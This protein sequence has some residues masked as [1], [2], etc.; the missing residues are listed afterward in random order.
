[1]IDP[2][3]RTHRLRLVPNLETSRSLAFE[4]VIRELYP[5]SVQPGMTPSAAAASVST[6]GPLVNGKPPALL[7]KLGRYTERASQVPPGAQN[8][9]AQAAAS[10]GGTAAPGASSSVG[11][12]AVGGAAAGSSAAGSVAPVERP[13]TGISGPTM[14]IAGGGG[15]VTAARVAFKSKVVSRSHAEIW[16]D[17]SGKVSSI[18]RGQVQEPDAAD[19]QFYIRD[20]ASSSGTF[21][22]NIRLSSPNTASRHTQINDGDVLQLGVDYQGGQED[23]FR[24]IKMRVEVGREWQRGANEFKWVPLACARGAG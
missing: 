4:P 24:C 2:K 8:V 1:V 3:G 6:L 9:A 20:T 12:A 7:L 13:A 22:N 18:W 23:M 5:I 21:L 14:T 16:C 17:S 15:E 11:G 19:M 10:A